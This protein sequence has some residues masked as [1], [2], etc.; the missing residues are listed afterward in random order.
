MEVLHVLPLHF[1]T[2]GV[3]LDEGRQ[4]AN[5]A[6]E[7]LDGCR[8]G[9]GRLRLVEIEEGTDRLPAVIRRLDPIPVPC[10]RVDRLA[11]VREGAV[12][13]RSGDLLLCRRSVEF[14]DRSLEPLVDGTGIRG[15]RHGYPPEVCPLGE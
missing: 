13:A 12:A 7:N 11:A 1:A 4:Q 2:I 15:S 8:R 3:D 5:G 9:A 10:E 6:S 14:V